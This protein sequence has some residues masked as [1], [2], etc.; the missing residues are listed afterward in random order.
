MKPPFPY[1]G[2]KT[3]VAQQIV[4]LLPPHGHYVEPFAGSLAVLL[5]KPVSQLETVNDINSDLVTFFR[6]LRDQ[7]DELIR[8]C[9]LT[10]HSR[11]EHALSRLREDLTELERARR[12]F[13]NLSQGRSASLRKTGWAH[14][15]NPENLSHGGNR[16]YRRTCTY[17]VPHSRGPWRGRCNLTW[18]AG[19]LNDICGF[20]G[21]KGAACR[22]W[23]F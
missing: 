17:P 12:T 3:R 18:K 7:P 13:V 9:A 5:A 16:S 2:G 1:Y 4:D 21:A 14:F 22:L 15:V 20:L 11:E 8:I 6:V 23:R 19:P 10:P